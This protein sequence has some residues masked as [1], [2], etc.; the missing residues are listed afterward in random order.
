METF[1]ILKDEEIL[2]EVSMNTLK[3][4]SNDSDPKCCDT[5]YD[6]NVNKKAEEVS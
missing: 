1:K 3:G 4:G 2:N 6:C 5:N